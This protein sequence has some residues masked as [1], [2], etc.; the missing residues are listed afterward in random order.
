MHFIPTLDQVKSTQNQRACMTRVKNMYE[1]NEV[2]QDIVIW[3]SVVATLSH[4]EEAS[5]VTYAYFQNGSLLV[6]VV[7]AF[8]YLPR[9]NLFY[10]YQYRS[11]HALNE[12]KLTV[13]TDTRQNGFYSHPILCRAFASSPQTMEPFRPLFKSFV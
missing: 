11:R 2:C 5:Y 8:P 12:C 9:R 6:G 13:N 4:R 10:H 3:H 7:R 1:P